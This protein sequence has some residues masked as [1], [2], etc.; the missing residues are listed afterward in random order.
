[1][2]SCLSVGIFCMFTFLCF[3]NVPCSLIKNV[4]S[5]KRTELLIMEQPILPEKYIHDKM[6]LFLFL[7]CRDSTW[8][9]CYRRPWG[10][11]R[12]GRSGR[13]GCTTDRTRRC[14]R[15]PAPSLP[16]RSSYGT[17]C[18][19]SRLK[20]YSLHWISVLF[21]QTIHPFNQL[22]SKT[23]NVTIQE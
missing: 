15:G 20:M 11:S 10:R 23:E 16:F 18:T 19:L 3:F 4:G 7:T 22:S 13:P 12:R 2:K 17:Y 9:S 1:M 21:V 5:N 14:P 6:N 8:D